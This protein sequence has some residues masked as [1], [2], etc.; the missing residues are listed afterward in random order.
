MTWR[1]VQGDGQ[2]ETNTKMVKPLSIWHNHTSFF[3]Q[4]RFRLI[5]H[6]LVD[7]LEVYL[8]SIMHPLTENFD[9]DK[10]YII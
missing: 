7:T 4:F 1:T 3:R 9:A 10:F 8:V 6:D 5:L 2:T